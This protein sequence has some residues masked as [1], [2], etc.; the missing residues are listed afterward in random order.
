M[1]KVVISSFISLDGFTEAPNRELVAPKFS[2]DLLRYFIK[3]NV[4]ES[5]VFV[6]GRIT[7]EG[8][9]SYWT[10]A[11]ADKAEAAKL[12]AMRKVVF[13]RT[14]QAANWGQV[15]IVRDDIAGEVSRLRRETDKDITVLGS[16]NLANGF[17]KAGVVDEYRLLLNPTLLGGG[18]RLFEG[19]YDR[20]ELK[21]AEV[22]PFDTGAVL[23]TYRRS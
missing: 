9:V 20:F 11:A 3:P 10:S 21:L 14:L 19:G 23:L 4:E 15:N 5:G 16:A 13:S 18:T 1:S 12:A 2:P 7:Y 17:I 6:Y 22:R 8:M